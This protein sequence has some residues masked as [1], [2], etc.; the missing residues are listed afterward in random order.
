[1]SFAPAVPDAA[2]CT[3]TEARPLAL[4]PHPTQEKP[5]QPTQSFL[6]WA[7]GKRW[8]LSHLPSILGPFKI[9]RYHEPFLGGGAVFFG[10]AIAGDAYLSDLNAELIETY[11]EIRDN[12]T[13]V[14]LLLAEHVITA[15]HYYKIRESNPADAA[16]RAAR[17]IYL[18]QTSYNGIY[19]VNLSGRYNVPFGKPTGAGLPDADALN[20]VSRKLQG[21]SIKVQDF[22]ATIANVSAGDLVFLDP[23]YSV[24]HNNN[25]FVKY[26]QRLFSFTDQQRLSTLIDGIKALDAYYILTNAAHDSIATLFEK[27][28]RR[29]ELKRGNSIGGSQAKRGSA[30]EYVFTNVPFQ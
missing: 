23:P 13:S 29:V 7:G 15:E 24:A 21:A 30:S 28:D 10:S 27:G 25:G 22:Q 26:N 11:I 12:A 6:R 8:L 14:S 2:E 4:E 19:R 9:N 18:N 3:T 5:A 1:M 16:R 20:A 17:F